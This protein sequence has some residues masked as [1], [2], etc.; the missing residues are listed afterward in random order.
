MSHIL[1][2]DLNKGATRLTNILESD[3]TLAYVHTVNEAKRFARQVKFDLVII[4]LLF[5]ES[6]M[7]ELI[8]EFKLIPSL[9][10]TPVMGFSD[11][12]TASSI[13]SR[14]SI[15][16]SA[17]ALGVCDYVDTRR[18]SDREILDRINSCLSGKLGVGRKITRQEATP[19]QKREQQERAR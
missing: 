13:T 8:N 5:D 16:G 9:S 10:E 18:L 17:H 4:G 3:H 14:N 7:Y 15:E 1:I 19:T 11:Q 2:A 6:R 12:A